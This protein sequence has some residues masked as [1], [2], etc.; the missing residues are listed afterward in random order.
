MSDR[1]TW[2]KL[3]PVIQAFVNGEPVQRMDYDHR[4]KDTTVLRDLLHTSHRIRPPRL[5]SGTWEQDYTY[6]EPG[7]CNGPVATGVLRWQGT[8]QDTPDWPRSH[9]FVHVGKPRFIPAE[10]PKQ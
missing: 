3:L 7:R 5:I 9:G 10:E 2:A 8:D 1:E 4:W 6:T